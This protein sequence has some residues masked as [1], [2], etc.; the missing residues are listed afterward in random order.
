MQKIQ[1]NIAALVK[2]DVQPNSYI[3][4]LKE[5]KGTRRL[6][7]IIGAFEARSIVMALEPVE[8]NRPMTH[9][10]FQDALQSFNIELKEIVISELHDGVFHSTL[11]CLNEDGSVMGIDSRTSDAIAL[12]IRFDS[13]I[14]VK[15]DILDEA[16]ILLEPAEIEALEGEVSEK[17]AAPKK[18]LDEYDDDAL[19]DFLEEAISREDYELAAKIRDE[20]KR[21][22]DNN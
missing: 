12:A 13:D 7:I 8:S 5:Q 17:E 20:Q 3:I 9:D 18:S 1:L 2:S 10:L 15:G 4:V 16:G 6:P 11:V 22:K 14:Y 19:G 21:R